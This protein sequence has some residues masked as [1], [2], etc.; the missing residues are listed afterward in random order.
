MTSIVIIDYGMGNLGSIQ[1]MLKKI[2][3]PAVI[4][5][6]PTVV[7]QAAKLI[8]PG[9]GAFDHAMA[10]L[11]QRG[12]TEVIQQRVAKGRPLLGICLGMQLLAHRS[13][14][15]TLPGLGLVPG[16][17]VKFSVPA[18]LKIPHMGWNV[19]QYQ[20]NSPLFRG[21]ANWDEARF[22][23]VHSYYYQCH[24]PGHVAA[25]T[26]YGTH[27]ASA[28]QNGLVFGT[29]FHPEKSHKF[30]LLLLRNFA[31]L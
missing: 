27:F 1:N 13:D 5:S 18:P 22:Y 16:Q 23:F 2:G 19:V 8:L 28:V 25:T 7:S 26:W 30:G 20:A 31:Q 6:E 4:A 3:Q 15:G 12:L 9:V 17:V 11:A 29:Q 10:N 24:D 21:F 14:E